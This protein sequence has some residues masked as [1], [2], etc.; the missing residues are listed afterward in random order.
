ML[1]LS[2]INMQMYSS[3]NPTNI[4]N[5]IMDASVQV[6]VTT[7]IGKLT[8]YQTTL[9]KKLPW[10]SLNCDIEL[11]PNGYLNSYNMN[12]VQLI[13]CEADSNTLWLLPDVVQTS[14]I[15]S[16]DHPRMEIVLTWVLY[17]DR[18]KGKEMVKS[19][20]IVDDLP[21]RSDVQ[22]V[23]NGST[24]KFSIKNVFPRFFRVTGSGEVRSLE[25]EVCHAFLI[26]SSITLSLSLRSC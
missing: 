25:I 12:D 1:Y 11:D 14:F 23:L 6:D 26:F 9:C 16:L 18:P 17:R 21:A 15:Q 3:G 7:V 8:L 19:D 2:F 4:A 22:K 10:E 20:W 5:P 24:T 13:T